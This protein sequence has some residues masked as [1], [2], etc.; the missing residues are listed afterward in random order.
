MPEVKGQ[1][2]DEVR[3]IFMTDPHFSAFNPP[4][5]KQ[6]TSYID[7]LEET[8][9][10]VFEFAKKNEVDAIV[11]GGD[12]F[13]LKSAS[14]NPLWF[15]ARV[16]SFF[17]KSNL[18]HIGIAGNHDI[19]Y[20]SIEGMPGQPLELLTATQTIHLLDEGSWLFQTTDFSV[21]VAGCSYEHSQSKPV[22]ELKKEG[23]TYLVG[24]GHFWFGKVTGEFFGEPVHGPDTLEKSEVDVYMI[25]HHHDDQG[26]QVINGK[27]YVVAGSITR[28]GAHK[29]DLIRRPAAVYVVITKEGVDAKV[30]RPRVK[31][32]DQLIDMVTREQMM[33]ESKAIDE[34]IQSLSGA[35]LQAS[36]PMKVVDE[37]GLDQQVKECVIR[38]L[39]AAEAER[40]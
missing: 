4:S 23:A 35:S 26:V 31:P 37:L 25:G 33:E 21:R 36:D 22:R 39:E 27:T 2:S 16:L 3:L 18:L 15:M 29:Q 9:K 20:G 38:Y 14:R 6:G 5:W 7:E 30:L 19:K 40:A 28:T 1:S 34:F 17:R 11:W 8:V 10:Q 13:N 24:V 12:F 32:L